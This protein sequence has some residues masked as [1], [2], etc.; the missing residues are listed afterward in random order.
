MESVDD[1]DTIN[2]ELDELLTRK[3]IQ[4]CRDSFLNTLCEE[5]VGNLEEVIP[6]EEEEDAENNSWEEENHEDKSK[7]EE[8]IE[9]FFR[10]DEE[11]T[12]SDAK[13]AKGIEFIIHD[14]K[15][16][17]NKMI[18]CQ[19]ERKAYS[20]QCAR[21]IDTNFR[22]AYSGQCA[23]HIDTNFRKAYSGQELKLMF[24]AGVKSTIDWEFK[25]NMERI[26]EV[27]QDAYAH[28]RDDFTQGESQSL[29]K[30]PVRR[31]P[32]ERIT[33]IKLKTHVV[34]KQGR[35]MSA[36]KALAID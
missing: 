32:S 14:P 26:R 23:R 25:G 1:F 21:H 8:G 36:E 10:D 27:N 18:P 35:G 6:E 20:G 9:A 29:K 2:I 24:W 33:L 3:P 22:K 28:T 16:K 30:L 15:I 7:E 13:E 11:G 5:D 4:R 34:D 17:W 12:D 31:K 19:G